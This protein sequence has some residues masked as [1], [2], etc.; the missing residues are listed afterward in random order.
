[1]IKCKHCGYSLEKGPLFRIN[2][3]CQPGIFSHEHCQNVN[4]DKDVKEITNV[5][6][7]EYEK[8]TI[9]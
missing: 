3:K 5:I 7:K 2:E 6:H 9:H 8:P 4:I 1:M